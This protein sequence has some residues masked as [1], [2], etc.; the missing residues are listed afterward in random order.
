MV[1]LGQRLGYTLWESTRRDLDVEFAVTFHHFEGG[2]AVK[3]GGILRHATCD[4]EGSS[5]GGAQNLIIEKHTAFQ[6]C[7]KMSAEVASSVKFPFESWDQNFVSKLLTEFEWPHI[8]VFELV[9]KSNQ[10]FT[11]NFLFLKLFSLH[12]NPRL[13][14]DKSVEA[15]CT[16]TDSSQNQSATKVFIYWATTWLISWEVSSTTN[17]PRNDSFKHLN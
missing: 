9:S 17:Q 8:S 3:C 16:N 2:K 7:S 12:D 15:I 10:E 6:G 1:S 14:L 5:M 13:F 4:R 11:R